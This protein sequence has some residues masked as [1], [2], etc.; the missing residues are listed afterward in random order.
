MEIDPIYS[1]CLPDIL[2]KLGDHKLQ[3][4][5][6][7]TTLCSFPCAVAYY[8]LSHSPENPGLGDKFNDPSLSKQTALGTVHVKGWI[9]VPHN[10]LLITH[11]HW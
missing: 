5:Q 1:A 3:C 11:L 8:G 4:A 2:Y 10:S 6:K 7:Y 9:P